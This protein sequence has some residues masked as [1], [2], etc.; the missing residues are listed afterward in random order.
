MGHKATCGTRGG[1]R[2]R[3]ARAAALALA[4]GALA[5]LVASC[6]EE[7]PV[8]LTGGTFTEE[9]PPEQRRGL[10]LA[11]DGVELLRSARSVRIDVTQTKGSAV[12]GTARREQV[13]L[14][15]DRRSNCTGTFDAGP[16][17]S[18]D[19]I[20]IGGTATY[21]RFSDESLDTLV[22]MGEARGP[23]AA[24]TVRERVAL[25][26]GKY[27]KAPTEATGGRRA[28]PAQQCDLDE[29]VRK[30]GSPDD[31]ENSD[32]V[33]QAGS[34]TYRYGKH[35]IPIVDPTGDSDASMY[36]AAEGKPY[37]AAFE[38]EQNGQR[39]VMKMSDYDEPVEAH[40]PPASQVVEADDIRGPGARTSSRS[41]RGLT[42]A[43][44]GGP[45]RG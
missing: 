18:G 6:G 31:A 17:R 36:V 15:I 2:R 23:Q 39:M 43:R 1:G 25:V 28:T 29:L 4:V 13:A 34:P 20:V 35:V 5:P 12:A 11:V 33:F 22:R 40:A 24:A 30:L 27:L 21:I 10:E 42:G 14:H 9:L 7:E 37:I 3:R 32:D 26:R 45:A 16:G 44:P 38:M 19:L 41:D 8:R